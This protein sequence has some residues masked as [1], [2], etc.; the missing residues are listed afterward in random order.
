MVLT[1]NPVGADLKSILA[2][3]VE[4]RGPNGKPWYPERQALQLN[5]WI[6]DRSAKL[7]GLFPA[8]VR[9]V[10]LASLLAPRCYVEFAYQPVLSTQHFRAACDRAASAGRIP[11]ATVGLSKDGVVLL[12]AKLSGA[13]ISTGFEIGFSQMP[14]LAAFLDVLHNT[15]GYASVADCLRG[16]ITTSQPTVDAITASKELRKRFNAWLGDGDESRRLESGHRRTQAKVIAA[17]LA[18]C[19][20]EKPD[21]IG[22]NIAFSFWSE[23]ASFWHQ[24]AKTSKDGMSLDAVEK[25]ATDEGFRLYGTTVRLLLRYRRALEDAIVENAEKSYA[26]Q[27][28]ANGD[29]LGDLDRII[30][31]ELT[32]SDEDDELLVRQRI[33]SSDGSIEWENPL[34][35]ITKHPCNQI[36]W[37]M[38]SEIQMLSNYL[39]SRSEEKGID[40]DPNSSTDAKITS[41]GDALVDY[42]P[43]DL[44]LTLTLLRVDVFAAAQ[45]RIIGRLRK[46]FSPS[47]ALEGSI[48]EIPDSAYHDTVCLY[49]KIRDQVE[50]ETWATLSLLGSAGDPMVIPLIEYL[51]GVP[52]KEEFLASVA[53]TPTLVLWN[54]VTPRQEATLLQISQALRK[55]FNESRPNEGLL[56]A[57]LIKKAHKARKKVARAGF[58][59]D[60]AGDPKFRLAMRSSVPAVIELHRELDRLIERLKNSPCLE[61][62]KEDRSA[63]YHVFCKLYDLKSQFK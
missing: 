17:Y 54:A 51:G 1:F 41:I 34:A 16:F 7:Q 42:G 55:A 11:S 56:L 47:L 12:E 2:D 18:R 3:L 39:G 46:G 26:I 22:D 23:R 13:R 37:L 38:D 9:F 63:F 30:A 52:L 35:I 8:V 20:I 29:P 5:R 49:E 27:V 32:V 31:V 60:D 10:R 4:R 6:I 36:K 61:L 15:I 53:V 24:K 45:A 21:D 58:R 14:H 28:G 19:G 40:I 48:N 59:L 44:R 57:N 50:T 62:A 25:G 33:S 43:F